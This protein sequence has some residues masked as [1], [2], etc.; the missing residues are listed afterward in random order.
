MASAVYYAKCGDQMSVNLSE[1]LELTRALVAQNTIYPPGNEEKAAAV[2]ATKLREAGIGSIV[3]EILPH[4]TNL[5]ARLKGTGKSQ[6]SRSRL[7][8]IRSTSTWKSGPSTPSPARCA[9]VVY[10]A[11]ALPT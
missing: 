8:S 3:Y 6:G 4:R 5:V 7:I 9:T 2:V 1:T 10:M 11:A